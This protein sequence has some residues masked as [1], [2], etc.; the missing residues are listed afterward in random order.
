MAKRGFNKIIA[1]L[2]LLIFVII[3][4]ILFRKYVLT[5]LHGIIPA[6][7]TDNIENIF[8][9][10][11]I[12]ILTYIFLRFSASILKS[13]LIQKGTKRDVKLLVSVYRY[14]IWIMVIFLTFSLLFK[15][16]GSLITSIGLIGFG[17]TLALQ[18]PILNFVGW[19][20]IVFTKTY[21]L[22]DKININN[23]NGTVY[24]IKLMYTAL[25]GLNE[26]G[27]PT[28]KSISIPN[29]FVLTTPVINYTK[30]TNY[31][32]DNLILSITY[33]SDWK[34]ALKISEKLVQEII[35][36]EVKGKT[37]SLFGAELK[38]YE[39]PITRF[40]L[41]DKSIQIKIRYLVDFDKANTIKSELSKRI[42]EEFSKHKDIVIGK[43]EQVG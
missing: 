13:Y 39:K 12:L 2:L 43:T 24:D 5:Y 41:T 6:S 31:V 4:Y 35:N 40:N 16:I 34:K 27:D 28:G 26:E 42:L 25:A 36:K 10:V 37:K 3:A 9:F 38:E 19:I 32:W 29:E 1:F 11:I 20:T 7:Y 30:G 14:V 22:G 8:I 17:L 18:K 21:K 33:R 15:Q 23:I